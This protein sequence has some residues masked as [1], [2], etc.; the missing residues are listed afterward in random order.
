Q[1]GRRREYAEQARRLSAALV[2]RGL[3]LVFGAGHIGLMGVLA[4]TVLA[5]GGEAIGVIPQALVDKELAHTGLTQT[6]VTKTMHD[7]KAIMADLADGFI[8]LP[9]GYGTC[10]EL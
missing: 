5:A 6:H 8:A 9:G 3:A 10:D 2:A 1:V 7:R 4:D